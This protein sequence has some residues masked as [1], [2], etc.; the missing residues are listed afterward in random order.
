MTEPVDEFDLNDLPPELSREEIDQ[1]DLRVGSVFTPAAPIDRDALFAGRL[2]QVRQVV[3]AINGRGQHAIIFGERGV[4]KTSLAN[5]LPQKFHSMGR[6]PILSARVNC[7]SGDSYDALWRRVFEELHIEVQT[8]APPGFLSSE[9]Q[10][11][12]RLSDVTPENIDV[13]DVKRLLSLASRNGAIVLIILDEFDRVTSS[14][15]RKQLVDTI[16]L[17][18]D[19]SVPVTVLLVGVADDVNEV[20]EEHAS[21]ERALVQVHLPRMSRE[22]IRDI[23]RKG[24]DELGMKTE[25]SVLEEIALLCQGLPHYAH[26]LGLYATRSGIQDGHR[27]VRTEH[28]HE[29][30][31]Q[32]LS[33][34][35]QSVQSAY[36][37]AT[38]SQRAG[39]LYDRVL[40]AC[41]LAQTD[42]LGFFSAADVREPLSFIMGRR[43]EIPSFSRHLHDLCEDTRGRILQRMGVERRFRFRFSSALMQPHVIM[44][45]IAAGLIDR[46]AL[47]RRLDL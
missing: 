11:T 47:Q 37:K 38:T 13:G 29:A 14:D 39:T 20:I 10:E 27:I 26:L 42:S 15:L 36:H 25:A 33:R 18:S 21:V 41:A 7:D 35:E 16:K 46:D 4:G 17:L 44:Q 19:Q 6:V 31:H 28:L 32:A 1:L 43:Y 30:I 34:V 5:I 40:L 12:L 22:E 2:V 9:G 23:I 3:D 8:K 45:G 24:H